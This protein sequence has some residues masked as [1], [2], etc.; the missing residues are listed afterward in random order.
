MK[1]YN[2]EE[3]LLALQSISEILNRSNE[4]HEMLQAVLIKLLELTGLTTGWMFL[5]HEEPH[6]T[7]IASSGLPQALSWGEATP[8]CTGRCWCLDRL[9]DGRLSRAANIISC[10]RIENAE[11]Y[12]W[13]DTEN[14]EHHAS[15]PLKAGDELM[16][17]LNLAAPGKKYFS[18]EE[19]TLLHTV[20][21]Q[22]GSAIKRTMFFHSERRRADRLMKWNE[23]SRFISEGIE[24]GL[25][26]EQIVQ[27]IGTSF[28]WP[29]TVLF[30]HDGQ[31]LYLSA[32]YCSGNSI[33]EGVRMSLSNINPVTTAFT[34]STTVLQIHNV[35]PYQELEAVGIKPFQSALSVPLYRADSV[36]GILLVTDEQPRQFDQQDAEVLE[37]LSAQLAL[38]ME[39][40]KLVIQRRELAKQ[41]ERHRLA[42][43]LHDSVS[44]TLFSLTLTARGAA[45][46]PE[47]NTEL[48][49]NTL[50]EMQNLSQ[51]AL[52][53]MRS[54]IANLRPPGLEHGLATGLKKYGEKLGLNIAT[55]VTGFHE[56]PQTVEEALWRIGQESMNNVSKHGQV[57]E[58]KLTLHY[59]NE[60]VRLEVSDQGKGFVPGRSASEEGQSAGMGLVSM[61]ERAAMLGG[62]AHII[63]KPGAGTTIVIEIPFIR[64]EPI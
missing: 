61:R 32:R 10:K 53:E 35:R 7:F 54:L 11:K 6:Y 42:R 57:N 24:T 38:S 55:N 8:M 50:L 62:F 17:V 1:H 40:A 60:S 41:E 56:L 22:I 2:R 64:S 37:A 13:G 27:G 59:K 51:H 16:G 12:M 30:L 34:G 19:L 9:W 63:S 23:A 58:V 48:L 25:L 4:T 29:N 3:Q 46:L 47:G 33:S 26:P 5:A 28:G 15:V 20:A 44:Q 21:Y 14:I 31:A 39:K 36:F 43:D 52:K 18:N 49:K 45:S